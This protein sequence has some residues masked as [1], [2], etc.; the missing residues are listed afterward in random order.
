MPYFDYLAQD[1]QNRQTKGSLEANNKAEASVKLRQ[2]GL[3][4]VWVRPQSYF[5]R[6][7]LFS[8]RVKSTDLAVFAQQMS[9]LISGGITVIRALKALSQEA[10]NKHLRE[11]IERISFDVENGLSLSTAFAK[12]PKVFSP[13][14]TSLIKSGESAGTLPCVLKRLAD[15]LEK[16]DSL[17]RKVASSLAYPMVVA[18]VATAA[19][20]F[21]LI[22]VVPTFVK[23]Y[24]T[25][26]VDLPV[27]T[28]VLIALSSFMVKFW[29][30]FLLSIAVF[31]YLWKLLGDR[32]APRL[33]FDG[34]T[35]KIPVLGALNRKVASSR[36]VR[37]LATLTGSGV[38]LN[39]SLPIVRDVV[40][41]RVFM[42]AVDSMQ[43]G[44]NRGEQLSQSLKA[45]GQFPAIAVE[46]VAAGEESGNLSAMLD[47][48]ADFL[49][50]D[51]DTLINNLVVKLEPA[52]TFI[53]ALIV[54]FITLAIYLPM[55]D[56]MR[57]ISS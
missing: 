7:L 3:Y 31:F 9:A 24:K 19:V 25:M 57:Q 26:R 34:F 36:F 17:R 39:S 48:C 1:A 49:D 53:L 21:L 18:F 23:V 11:V 4:I 40:G 54:G 56:L 5:S 35:L 41:N 45:C 47:K 14:C 27:P 16:E 15:Y 10:A 8:P 55:F 22:F 2:L 52:L 44:I 30:L 6:T 46:M 20:S 32:Q 29:W 33:C 13:F 50:K 43:A 51:I 38:T 12:H 28:V 42:R 37:T